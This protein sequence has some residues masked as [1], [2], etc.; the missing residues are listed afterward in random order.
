MYEYFGNENDHLYHRGYHEQLCKVMYLHVLAARDKIL[1]GCKK[2]PKTLC[3]F[4]FAT[5]FSPLGG[6]H[7]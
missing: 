3:T 6:Y 1:Y 7:L 2:G 5:Q 4:N